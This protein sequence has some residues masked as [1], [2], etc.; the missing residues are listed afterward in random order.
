MGLFGPITYTRPYLSLTEDLNFDLS[1]PPPTS[2]SPREDAAVSEGLA[3]LLLANRGVSSENENGGA[4]S[5]FSLEKTYFEG[6][7]SDKSGTEDQDLQI[8]HQQPDEKNRTNGKKISSLVVKTPPPPSPNAAATVPVVT[9]AAALIRNESSPPAKV[10]AQSGLSTE[11]DIFGG[12]WVWD[13]SIEPFYPPGSC[14]YIDDDFNCHKNGSLSCRGKPKSNQ[15]MRAKNFRKRTLDLHGNDTDDDEEERRLALE[16][17]KLRQKQREKKDGIPALSTTPQHSSV[18]PGSAFRKGSA[19]RGGG[20]GDK[21]DGDGGKE[22]LVLQDTF[23]Q[24]TAVTIEDPNM[25]KYVERELAKR[26][27]KRIDSGEKEEKDPMDELYVVP[28][29][30]KVKKRNSEESSTQW[31]TGIAEIQ[32]PIEYKLRNIEETEAAK[33]LLQEKRLVRKT[34]SELNIPSSYSADYFQRG[35]D[36]AE[37]LQRVASL[38]IAEHPE[39]Y[40]GQG[41]EKTDEVSFTGENSPRVLKIYDEINLSIGNDNVRMSCFFLKSDIHLPNSSPGED[42]EQITFA[43][44]LEADH[45]SGTFDEDVSLLKLDS[46]AEGVWNYY[47]GRYS[48]WHYQNG[49]YLYEITD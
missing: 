13:E 49:I 11:C 48:T 47:L 29:H 44:K 31:T 45:G 23:A 22:D 41:K 10:K 1:A 14:P 6:W 28:E 24:E 38:C 34:K 19:G 15:A 2:P 26:H 21:G 42:G 25:L 7:I 35:R 39:L 4:N 37:K 33:K 18:G 36:Y 16:E 3:D 20:G 5:S 8:T 46:L 17:V 43:G 9:D 32:L 12:R 40:K 27:G 30:L